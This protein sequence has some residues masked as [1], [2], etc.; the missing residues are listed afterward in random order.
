MTSEIKYDR[1][2]LSDAHAVFCRDEV[3]RRF[4]G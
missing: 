1:P 2:I 4:H 3:E